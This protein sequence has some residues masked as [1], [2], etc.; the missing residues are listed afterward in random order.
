ME[1]KSSIPRFSSIES[2]AEMGVGGGGGGNGV[3]SYGTRKRRDLGRG[4]SETEMEKRP[5]LESQNLW[6]FS[7]FFFRL[8]FLFFALWEKILDS[9]DTSFNLNDC[10]SFL[11]TSSGHPVEIQWTTFRD[12]IISK[13]P[14]SVVKRSHQHNARRDHIH[15]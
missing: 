1:K 3:H 2:R 12:N 11:R 6:S 10:L 8:P 14:E 5:I 7:R 4:P 15:I 13:I 9:I